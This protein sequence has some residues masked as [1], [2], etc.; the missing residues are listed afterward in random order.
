[1]AWWNHIFTGIKIAA[2]FLPGGIGMLVGEAVAQAELITHRIEGASGSKLPGLLKEDIALFELIGMLDNATG[3]N[4]TD[5]QVELARVA[6]KANVA[7]VNSF[8][9]N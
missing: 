5:E 8:K 6:F 3:D 7:L 9:D 1:M 2:G 4:I